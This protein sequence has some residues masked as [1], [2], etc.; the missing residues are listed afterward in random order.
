MTK[1]E[2][3]RLLKSDYWKGY[4]YSIIK[5]RNF[6]CEDCG[7]RFYNERNKLQVHHLVYRDVK[8]W[9]YKPE[10]LIVLCEECHKRRHGIISD[11]EHSTSAP[12]GSYNK[13]YSYS[14]RGREYDGGILEEFV[15]PAFLPLW[16]FAK[17]HKKYV[18]Y[19]IAFLF[20]WAIASNRSGDGT[21]S[22]THEENANR[23]VPSTQATKVVSSHRHSQKSNV[24]TVQDKPLAEDDVETLESEN[25]EVVE[26]HED[27]EVVEDGSP[28]MEKEE[29]V[30]KDVQTTT[31]E[32]RTKETPQREETTLE[33]LER[34]NHEDVV[35][36]AK[37]AGVSTEGSTIEILERINHADV[38]KQAK[39]AGVSTEGS[40]IEI[41]E[42]IN[43]A[44]VV[45]QAK[46]AGVST[47]G[48]TIE[49]LERINHADVVKQARRAGVSTE[50]STIDILER[51]NHADVVKQ[52]RRA[53]VS[54]EGSTIDILERINRKELEKY[55]R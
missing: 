29:V 42:R 4:S 16:R 24:A 45:K 33:I 11:A 47:E 30:P 12:M 51:I 28:Q 23:N 38:V 37:R 50:G 31:S 8:P 34:K 41:L 40:T 21:S 32:G 53:G 55:N 35:R 26:G 18:L 48:S 17:R 52:A 19:G 1:E 15:I 44:D 22:V 2:Y 5:E 9:S 14:H 49:I 27:I 39:R 46:R 54:T 43:H 25:T 20:I 36:Q 13:S 10:E 6:T 3:A 7:R